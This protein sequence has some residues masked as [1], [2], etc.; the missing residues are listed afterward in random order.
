MYREITS[1]LFTEPH[2]CWT[3]SFLLCQQ[4]SIAFIC[5]CDIRQEYNP[6]KPVHYISQIREAFFYFAE[7]E[8]IWILTAE[9]SWYS[10]QD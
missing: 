9:N 5:Y 6:I 10:S 7:W 8:G 2:L 3:S 4:L 1:D